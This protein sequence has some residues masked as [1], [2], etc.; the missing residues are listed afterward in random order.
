MGWAVNYKYNGELNRMSISGLESELEG[1]KRMVD[2]Y[3][4]EMLAYMSATPQNVKDCEGH[5]IP[6]PEH[7]A[8]KIAEYR[9]NIEDYYWWIHHIQDC[10]DALSEDKKNVTEG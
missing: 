6:Y 2:L 1:Y 5:E 9:E 7:L 4:R 8:V 3:W 10:L